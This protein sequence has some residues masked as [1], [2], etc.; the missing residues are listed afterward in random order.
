MESPYTFDLSDSRPLTGLS[1]PLGA[2]HPR[3]KAGDGAAAGGAPNADSGRSLASATERSVLIGA[4]DAALRS[5]GASHADRHLGALLG[6]RNDAP[7]ENLFRKAAT[8]YRIPN[9]SRAD[10]QGSR[11]YPRK[12]I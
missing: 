3:A 7:A 12:R 11:H 5:R 1:L 6:G 9:D 4:A 2:V 10:K 8:R